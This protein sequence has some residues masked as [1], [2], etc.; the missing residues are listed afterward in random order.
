MTSYTLTDW[1]PKGPAFR[2]FGGKWRARKTY[3]EPMYSTIIE[4]FA[5]A[6]NY[7][8][9]HQAERT[10]VADKAEHIRAAWT[11]ITKPGAGDAIRSLPDLVRGVDVTTQT[12]DPGG[13]ALMGLWCAYASFEPRTMPTTW[14]VVGCKSNRSTWNTCIR[15]RIASDADRIKHPW[16]VFHD[17]REIPDIEATWFID[18]PYVKQG[19]RYRHGSRQID[20][21]ALAAWCMSRRGQVIVC[22]SAGAM[23]LPFQHHATIQSMTSKNG[24][25]R[26]HEVIW[27][28]VQ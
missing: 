9:W 21:A 1:R 8:W 16:E 7:A 20:Y 14:A 13:A 24:D 27:T 6:A 19:H 3:P 26:C 5:G 10:I 23:W 25:D 15:S 12:D 17:Y 11:F 22:E 18:P 28:I 2:Y 4:P